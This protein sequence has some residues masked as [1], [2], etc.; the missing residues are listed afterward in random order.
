M[1]RIKITFL[2]LVSFLLIGTNLNAQSSLA[3]GTQIVMADESKKKIE[4]I[5]V[6]DEILVF[7][8]KDKVYEEREVTKINK[9]MMNRLVRVTL[10]NGVQ[11]IMTVEHPILAEK[12]WASIDPN[13][14]MINKKYQQVARY[15]LGEFTLFYNV[16]TTDYVE[17]NIIQG[18]LDP[19][20]T[21]SLEVEDNTENDAIVA[22]G[23]LVGLN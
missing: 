17:V 9:V 18:I 12:G 10:E 13:Q 20:N 19:I 3:A 6:G 11:L 21:Y 16:T 5:A 2:V 15:N 14:T 23:F 7:N 22:N 4:E 1:M 8:A